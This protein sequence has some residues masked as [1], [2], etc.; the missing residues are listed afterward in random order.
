MPRS[1]KGKNKLPCL[2]K[3]HFSLN[4]KVDDKSSGKKEKWMKK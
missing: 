3:T 1:R 4:W 2:C